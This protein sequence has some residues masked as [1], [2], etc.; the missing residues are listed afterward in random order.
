M[1]RA[2]KTRLLVLLIVA[3]AMLLFSCAKKTTGPGSSGNIWDQVRKCDWTVFFEGESNIVSVAYDS[4]TPLNETPAVTLS[5]DGDICDL[6]THYGSGNWFGFVF[7][8]LSPLTPGHSYEVILTVNGTASSTSFEIPCLLT[9]TYAPEIFNHSQASSFAW[10]LQKNADYQ[11]VEWYYSGEDGNDHGDSKQTATSTREYVI[12][13]N[14][15]PSNWG[16]FCFNPYVYN[17]KIIGKTAFGSSSGD[18]RWYY[19]NPANIKV[20]DDTRQTQNRMFRYR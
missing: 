4:N 17:I 10:S 14:R 3:G 12:P 18:E 20:A 11:F 2:L 6:Q 1:L 9:I 16:Y 8:Y 7:R 5:I 19:A 15:V 13:A